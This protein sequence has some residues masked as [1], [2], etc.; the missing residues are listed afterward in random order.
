MRYQLWQRNVLAMTM[1]LATF[2]SLFITYVRAFDGLWE[3]RQREYVEHRLVH[4]EMAYP[5]P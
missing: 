5:V 4:F 1:S 3:A 2:L